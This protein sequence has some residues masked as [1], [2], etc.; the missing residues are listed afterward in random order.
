MGKQ[1]VYAG[2]T[3]EFEMMVGKWKAYAVV[4]EGLRIVSRT[5]V[6]AGESVWFFVNADKPGTIPQPNRSI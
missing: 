2:A 4:V 5:N 3:G 6:E 1:T